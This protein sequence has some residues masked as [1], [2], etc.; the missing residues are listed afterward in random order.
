MTSKDNDFSND[1]DVDFAKAFGKNGQAFVKQWDSRSALV[2]Q[3]LKNVV[4]LLPDILKGAGVLFQFPIPSRTKELSSA[5]KTLIRRRGARMERKD[6][7]ERLKG[8]QGEDAWERY[9]NECNRP[10]RINDIGDFPDCDSLFEALHDIGGARILVYFPGDVQKV[11]DALQNSQSIIVRSKRK[12]GGG[13]APDMYELKKYVNR[14]EK[15]LEQEGQSSEDDVFAGYRATHIHVSLPEKPNVVIEIQ[16]ATVVMN[17]WSQVE[18]DVI[19]KPR[20]DN[21]P[22]QEEK[23]ILDMFNGTVMVGENALRQLEEMRDRREKARIDNDQKYARSIYDLGTWI[24][25]HCEDNGL[26][27]LEVKPKTWDHLEPLLE[28]LQA[29]KQHTSGMV[30]KL[31]GSLPKSEMADKAVFNRELPLH[32]L[33]QLHIDHSDLTRSNP[34]FSDTQSERQLARFLAL[35][36]VQTLNMSAY[37][38]IEEDFLRAVKDFLGVNGMSP[39][40]GDNIPS[41]NDFLDILH[42]TYSRVHV[43]ADE[44]I[45]NFCKSFLDGNKLRHFLKNLN[46]R[47]Q[48]THTLTLMELPLMLIEMG[49]EARPSKDWLND[50][51]TATSNYTQ[52]TEI[53]VPRSLCELL[54]DS[55]C[56]HW[57]PELLSAAELLRDMKEEG[58]RSPLDDM[59][60][61]TKGL[62]DIALQLPQKTSRPGRERGTFSLEYEFKNTGLRTKKNRELSKPW[63]GFTRESKHSITYEYHADKHNTRPRSN[64]GCFRAVSISDTHSPKWEY[65]KINPKEWDL[66]KTHEYNELT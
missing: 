66:K 15:T 2:S 26:Y 1:V 9:W 30:K 32:L 20:G 23:R 63:W 62:E 61:L 52:V 13:V 40:S 53:I 21:K 31:I 35:R 45:S 25:T 44:K 16:V 47:P 34:T 7:K 33:K 56:T 39:S 65:R 60:L 51:A 54:Y 12:R 29:R 50:E 4:E 46:S 14:L 58:C 17:A 57:A 10:D 43:N 19:Y 48:T 37:L 22:D 6:L 41:T 24:E 18:H 64:L 8:L 5:T 55:E 27:Q 38:G 49:L 3:E 11:A 28:V 36:V 42:P 59:L